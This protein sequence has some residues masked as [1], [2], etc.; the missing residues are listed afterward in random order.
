MTRSIYRI[1]FLF[2]A[3]GAIYIFGADTVAAQDTPGTPVTKNI[4]TK[5]RPTIVSG[6]VLNSKAISRPQPVYPAVARAA[7]AQGAVSVEVLVD[8]AGNVV[9][10]HPVS[11]HPKLREAAASA[12]RQAKFKPTLL[13]GTPVKVSG[14]I[15]YNFVLQ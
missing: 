15:T 5:R 2:V 11:G 12:A 4:S 6:G 7:K 3:L 10:A 9:S 8:E 13:S 14:V 1:L